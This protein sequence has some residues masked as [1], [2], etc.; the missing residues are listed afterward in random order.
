MDDL[1]LL[2]ELRSDT[3]PMT[4]ETAR[5][6]RAR[7]LATA[8]EAE[9]RTV[10][11]HAGRAGVTRRRLFRVAVAGGLVT[12]A[13]A[14]GIAVAGNTEKRTDHRNPGPGVPLRGT[15]VANVVDLADRAAQA[16]R[17]RPFTAPKPEQWI[18]IQTRS[19]PMAD[20]GEPNGPVASRQRRTTAQWI[21]ADGKQEATVD[22]NRKLTIDDLLPAEP[23][24]DYPYLSSLPT[25]PDRLLATLRASAD[26]P[27]G[28]RDVAVFSNIGVFMRNGLIPPQVQAALFQVLPR[29]KGVQLVRQ[30]TDA[31]GRTGVAFAIIEEGYLR[32]ELILDSRTYRYLGERSI[33]IK[34]HVSH[35]DD[36][37]LR[38]RKGEI[39]QW[40]AQTRIGVVDK[41]GQ[42]P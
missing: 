1:K 23:R 19:A 24:F 27:V 37:D 32:D 42:R 35:G 28:P 26:E 5:L 22:S 8:A 2:A 31:A 33:V 36:G 12:A 34:N 11:A 10:P 3:P 41:P 16:A 20:P 30:A 21:R 4:T 6:A 17:T 14:T 25:D 15:P 13:A 7:L 9:R 29:L 38:S 18:Y 40:A 39:V